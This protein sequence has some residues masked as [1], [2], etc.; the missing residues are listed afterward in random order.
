M[1][2]AWKLNGTK[3]A[4]RVVCIGD[5]ITEGYGI[6][7]DCLGPYPAQLQKKLGSDFI[8]YNQG[9]S[10]TCSINRSL[11]GRRVG[12]PY[13]LE[14]KWN[15]A[16]EIPG[17]I[18]VVMH[19]TNDAQNGYSEEMD[20]PDP[21]NDVYAFREFFREDYSKML[22]EIRI[23]R[24][25]AAVFSV[26]PVPVSD[27]CLW[28]KHQQIYLEDILERLDVIWMENPWLHTV[29]AQS[30]FLEIPAGER[31]ELYQEDGLHPSKK[32]SALI[33]ETIGNAILNFTGLNEEA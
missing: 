12:M 11:N 4:I 14:K 18:Y 13:V 6:S 24:P 32:G 10:S 30:V 19:G 20:S 21:Y 9:V 29:D 5:S 15:E 17:D 33:A 1:D 22:N 28:R 8:V 27:H 23:R 7:D 16:L 31:K 3:R 2:N 25:K 26:K